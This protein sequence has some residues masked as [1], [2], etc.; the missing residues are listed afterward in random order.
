MPPMLVDVIT[1]TVADKYDIEGLRKL[2]AQSFEAHIRNE[3]K[4]QAFAMA[5][6]EIYTNTVDPER[7]LRDSVIAVASS[8]A[9][10]LCKEEYGAY[11]RAAV[12]SV[13]AFASELCGALGDGAAFLPKPVECET[14]FYTC[15]SCKARWTIVQALNRRKE[16]AC[17]FCDLRYSGEA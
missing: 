1:H 11:F 2:A 3:W 7:E 8:H 15:P 9:E 4:G 14:A 6:E 16:Y 17:L 12:S 13:P 10:D 5:I